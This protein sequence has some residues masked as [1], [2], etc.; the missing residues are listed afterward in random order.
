ME[1]N[2]TSHAQ[3]KRN[4]ATFRVFSAWF[5]CHRGS[6]AV[7]SEMSQCR[8]TGSLGAVEHSAG[9]LDC[10]RWKHLTRVPPVISIS[11]VYDELYAWVTGR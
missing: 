7:D 5:V 3:E 4:I 2:Q 1:E 6:R 9:P 11:H 10:W 8:Q